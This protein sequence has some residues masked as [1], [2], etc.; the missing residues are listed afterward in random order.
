MHATLTFVSQPVLSRKHA[1]ILFLQTLASSSRASS[2]TSTFLPALA[3]PPPPSTRTTPIPSP[4]DP[5]QSTRLPRGKSKAEILKDYRAKTGKPLTLWFCPPTNSRSLPG[6]PH[7]SEDLLL[8]DTLYLLQGISGKY[9]HF[10]PIDNDENKMNLVFVDDP[11]RSVLMTCAL[12]E[13][14]ALLALHD[15]ASH[16]SPH[17]QTF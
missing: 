11:V 14:H 10:A 13:T 2:F 9:V 6:R 1:S 4:A 17:T 12:R 8:R 15:T 16:S 7:L 5:I 3:P